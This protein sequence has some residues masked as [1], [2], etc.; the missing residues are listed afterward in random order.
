MRSPA[1]RRSK[2]SRVSARWLTHRARPKAIQLSTELVTGCLSNTE[3]D[4]LFLRA[5]K[6]SLRALTPTEKATVAPITGHVA[7]SVAE[8]ALQDKF[9]YNIVWHLSGPG[10]RGVDLIVLSPQSDKVLAIEVKGTLRSGH[11][12]RMSGRLLK[13]MTSAWLDK[14][15]NPGMAEWGFT[16]DDLFGGILQM[17]LADMVMWASLTRDFHEWIPVVTHNQLA[18]LDW[19]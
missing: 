7:E 11:R 18:N 2:S 8:L 5:W 15:D 12:P 3:A 4:Q 1:A 13:Q 10:T 6:E 14:P 17:N 16:S 9:G 19:L